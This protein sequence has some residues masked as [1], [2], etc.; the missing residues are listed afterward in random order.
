M[1]RAPA[2]TGI[3]V[4][5]ASIAG[6]L[7]FAVLGPRGAFAQP[8]SSSP[9]TIAP[10]EDAYP[11]VAHDGRI[12]F[13]SNR[14]G[15][16]RLFVLDSLDGTAWPLDTGGEQEVTPVWSP[17]GRRIVFASTR[18]DNED[19]YVIRA[20]GTGLQRLTTDPAS[21]SHPSWSPDGRRIV[22]CSTRGD[23]DNDDVYVMNADGSDVRRLT[24]NGRTWDTFPSFS[25]DGTRILFRQLYRPRLDND[26]TVINSE[27][28]VMNADGT[29]V[30]NLSRNPWFDGWP[31]WSPDG[32]Q[33]AFS[34]N[35]TDVYQIY[36]MDADG[37]NVRVVAPAPIVQV[38]PQWSPDGTWLIFNQEHDGAIHLVRAPVPTA[39]R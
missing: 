36:V 14:L 15:G 33:V 17:D 19:V 9:Q 21:D 24:D 35:R 5:V 32:T 11:H 37:G 4:R 22:F 6:V 18:D 30:T 26:V 29:G 7:L 13:Q 12:V 28:M 16:S 2:L 10:V 23:G 3:A 27:I 8:W 31:S 34:S 25:P 1:I 38:R 39:S 20:D